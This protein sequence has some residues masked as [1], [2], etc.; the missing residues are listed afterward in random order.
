MTPRNL[1]NPDTLFDLDAYQLTGLHPDARSALA[2]FS[3]DRL[4]EL[5]AKRRPQD[6]HAFVLS[7][8]PAV[9]LVWQGLSR[10]GREGVQAELSSRLQEYR[11]LR[12]A[13]NVGDEGDEDA[14]AASIY[15]LTAF[16]EHNVAAARGAV[17]RLIEFAMWRAQSE[18]DVVEAADIKQWR[19]HPGV[20]AELRYLIRAYH[21]V[22]AREWT[23]EIVEVLWS[24]LDEMEANGPNWG[25]ES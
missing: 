8:A 12:D 19:K 25:G 21:Y 3:A 4:L 16:V 14:A 18:S 1:I 10:P 2:A 15:A 9:A 13:G 23:P 24:L 6:Q 11:Q 7:W 17:R 20:Q 5:Y 22:K